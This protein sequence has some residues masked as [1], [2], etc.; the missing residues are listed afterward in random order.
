M[1]NAKAEAYEL[2][3]RLVLDETHLSILFVIFLR[4]EQFEFKLPLTAR[5]ITFNENMVIF[6]FDAQLILLC[7]LFNTIILSKQ[8]S[9]LFIDLQAKIIDRRSICIRLLILLKG[10]LFAKACDRWFAS[11]VRFVWFCGTGSYGFSCLD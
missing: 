1:I 4:V 11:C 9:V 10:N 8:E 3:A 5:V 2:L 7:D 6:I